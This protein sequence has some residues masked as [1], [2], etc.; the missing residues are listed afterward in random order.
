[1]HHLGRPGYGFYDGYNPDCY[2]L[3][4]LHRANPWPPYC[5]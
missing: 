3:N 5:S 4:Y 2:D 1:M